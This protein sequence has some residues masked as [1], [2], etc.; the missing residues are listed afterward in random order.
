MLH[1]LHPFF[2]CSTWLPLRW[3]VTTLK[4][5]ASESRF[6]VEE[7][8][9]SG[10]TCCRTL[11]S[12]LLSLDW[13]RCARSGRSLDATPDTTLT[14]CLVGPKVTLNNTLVRLRC[15]AGLP[16][17]AALAGGEQPTVDL[18]RATGPGGEC[19][20][21]PRTLLYRWL[22]PSFQWDESENSKGC[23]LL[24]SLRWFWGWQQELCKRYKLNPEIAATA[25]Y[26]EELY[27]RDLGK[28]VTKTKL[29]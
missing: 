16:H 22:P 14:S 10:Q 8:I 4:R 7:N 20:S 21:R 28:E 29:S 3:Q 5:R 2:Y 6:L 26:S 18:H 15:A 13:G 9:Y 12:S 23:V 27:T 24:I 25:T 19:A 11:L 17:E 1:R